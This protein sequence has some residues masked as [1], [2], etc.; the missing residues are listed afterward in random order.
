LLKSKKI[1]AYVKYNYFRKDQ[2]SGQITTSQNNPKLAKIRERLSNFLI[3]ARASNS[4]NK[5]AMMLNLFLHNSNTTKILNDSC[6][7]GK[8][9]VEVEIGILAIA[10]NL[11]K[12]SKAA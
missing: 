5:D 10:H 11:N 4:E 12:M 7:E 1:K 2:K 9:K 6:F 3:P 8:N